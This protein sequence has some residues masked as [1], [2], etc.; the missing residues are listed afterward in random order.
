MNSYFSP[1]H[2]A[3]HLE[4]GPNTENGVLSYSTW[5]WVIPLDSTYLPHLISLTSVKSEILAKYLSWEISSV[6]LKWKSEVLETI[7]LLC[8]LLFPHLWLCHSL[9]KTPSLSF[10]LASTVQF[11]NRMNEH[12]RADFLSNRLLWETAKHMRA[13]LFLFDPYLPSSR[14]VNVSTLG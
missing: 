12:Q 3:S 4:I 1:G 13:A 11:S 7:K 10:F 5:K 9:G 8:N 6:Q 14:N 2:N